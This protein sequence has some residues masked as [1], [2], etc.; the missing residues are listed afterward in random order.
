MVQLFKN[1]QDEYKNIIRLVRLNN[2]LR[3]ESMVVFYKLKF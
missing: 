1:I 2:N 3:T